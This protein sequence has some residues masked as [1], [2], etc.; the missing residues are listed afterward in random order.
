MRD[1]AMRD[2]YSEEGCF[3][4]DWSEEWLLGGRNSCA[5]DV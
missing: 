2:D 1:D 4:D 5:S 3:V